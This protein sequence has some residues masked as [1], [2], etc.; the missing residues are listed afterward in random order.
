MKKGRSGR[1]SPDTSPISVAQQLRPYSNDHDISP[2]SSDTDSGLSRS[3]RASAAPKNNRD[4]LEQWLFSHV[5]QRDAF[6]TPPT[7][8]TEEEFSGSTPTHSDEDISDTIEVHQRVDILDEQRNVLM[9]N[10]GKVSFVGVLPAIDEEGKIWV[11]V[12]LDKPL[13]DYNCDAPDDVHQLGNLPWHFFP[14]ERCR[15]AVAA[16][17]GKPNANQT[18][19]IRVRKSGRS[20]PPAPMD[21]FAHPSNAKT[22]HEAPNF[23]LKLLGQWKQKVVNEKLKRRAAEEQLQMNQEELGTVKHERDEA[24]ARLQTETQHRKDLEQHLKL[25]NADLEAWDSK[26][27]IIEQ[28]Y[29]ELRSADEQYI[30][31]LETKLE[32]VTDEQARSDVNS[33]SALRGESI[34]DLARRDTQDWPEDILH[35]TIP[36]DDDC[37]IRFSRSTK[38]REATP[39]PDVIPAQNDKGLLF[40]VCCTES[41][42]NRGSPFCSQ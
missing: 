28:R 9:A 12:D 38:S 29:Q 8:D 10:C 17:I 40:L 1:A 11:G 36:G 41:N 35:D 20:L 7:S 19:A 31:D 26:M 3:S 16:K 23:W 15:V 13:D 6:S 4:S 32:R 30:E 34:D 21:S 42:V 24:W 39:V 14:L 25:A 2:L 18:K 27:S 5:R 33:T 22:S 37:F